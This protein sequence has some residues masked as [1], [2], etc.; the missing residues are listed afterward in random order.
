MPRL[1]QA[2]FENLKTRKENVEN[3][4]SKVFKYYLSSKAFVK[5]VVTCW[6]QILH[7]PLAAAL[8][9]LSTEVSP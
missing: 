2:H 4:N 9:R 1:S 5:S 8:W 3:E 6:T 7:E